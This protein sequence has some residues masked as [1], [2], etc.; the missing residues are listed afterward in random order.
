MNWLLCLI[1]LMYLLKL[2]SCISGVLNLLRLT[3][4]SETNGAFENLI[5]RSGHPNV[6]WSSGCSL[7]VQTR[8]SC[9]DKKTCPD[10]PTLREFLNCE[11][12][13]SRLDIQIGLV[14]R[15]EFGHPGV[16]TLSQIWIMSCEVFH[17]DITPVIRTCMFIRVAYPD[18][19]FICPD[20]L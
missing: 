14:I 17:S 3:S 8:V 10:I 15:V 13:S 5:C 11:P 6:M 20:I 16:L 4:S 12:W 9:P 1:F 19:S 7:V 18:I 2:R